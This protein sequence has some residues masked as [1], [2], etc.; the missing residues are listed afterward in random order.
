[1]QGDVLMNARLLIP[2]LLFALLMA[3]FAS[4]AQDGF[5]VLSSGKADFL[6]NDPTIAGKLWLIT[7]SQNGAGMSAV[8]TF[9]PD[10][11]I[12][13]ADGF[14]AQWPLTISTTTD[15][16]QIS[17]R[18]VKSTSAV[19]DV[20]TQ[21]VGISAG[22]DLLTP[23]AYWNNRATDCVNAHPGANPSFF[24]RS[25]ETYGVCIWF[26]NNR[27]IADASPDVNKNFKVT[28]TAV[29]NG[30]T[31]TGVLTNDKQTSVWLGDRVYATWVGSAISGFDVTFPANTQFVWL[32]NTAKWQ[33][34]D[35]A[36]VTNYKAALPILQ[37]CLAGS[38][39]AMTYDACIAQYRS[40]TA[41][42]LAGKQVSVPDATAAV[43]TGGEQDGQFVVQLSRPIQF[44]LI[45]MKI[46]ADF[47][48]FV[49][50][51]GIPKITSL[52][53]Q[54]ELKTGDTLNEQVTVRNIGAYK[55]SFDVYAECASPLSGG[56]TRQ[57]M[58]LAA[59]DSDSRFIP[60]TGR[61][62]KET[63]AKCTFTAVDVS[64]PNSK[65]TLDK[66]YTCK[67]IV[68]CNP[69]EFRCNGAAI[70]KCM[71]DGS[72]FVPVKTC[73]G[74]CEIDKSNA[75]VCTN[76]CQPGLE[77]CKDGVTQ[78]CASDGQSYTKKSPAETCGGQDCQAALW[79][80]VPA[81]TGN[82]EV[83]NFWCKVGITKPTVTTVC[84]KDYTP[85]IIIIVVLALVA[86]FSMYAKFKGKRG[87]KHKAA[88]DWL[89]G[90][91]GLIRQKWFWLGILL[92]LAFALVVGLWTYFFWLIVVLAVLAIIYILIRIF[93][94][95][96]IW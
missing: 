62:D 48:G 32:P 24:K 80:L 16:E 93:V 27:P 96:K 88:P 49:Q 59:Q 56:N 76:T 17:W 34:V 57:R 10:Q 33:A 46:K 53:P 19:S 60:I 91:T 64:N 61:C 12:D 92:V 37:N 9:T 87:N 66:T 55:G 65:S 94:F 78:V 43:A 63:S 3:T 23:W 44:P 13:T 30:Q 73:P 68:S 79:G 58:T 90:E 8:G 28:L 54:S 71:A 52:G 38:I 51:V 14:K 75:A 39:S 70:E 81:Q 36:A 47:I 29:A 35:S 15:N 4:A 85:L 1:M 72:K 69:D 2:V 40:A 86:I 77:V 42:A 83:C 21:N 11:M 84:V 26:N 41:S 74:S 22:W 18:I 20:N 89:V 82:S 50:L 5:F 6:S 7:V 25:M 67:T 31:A 45:T 95:G